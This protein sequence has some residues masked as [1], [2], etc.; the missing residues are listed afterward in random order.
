MNCK[1]A[2]KWRVRGDEM[3][4]N[5]T[6]VYLAVCI[7]MFSLLSM[8][9]ANHYLGY[10]LVWSITSLS[11]PVCLALT[12]SA[13][14]WRGL[15]LLALILLTGQMFG[16]A[17]YFMRTSGLRHPDI[18]SVYFFVAYLKSSGVIALVCYPVGFYSS[19]WALSLR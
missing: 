19:R 12:H 15:G 1:Y 18:E 14:F 3:Q 6:I 8:N 16:F 5:V 2:P 9:P 11:Y 13:G 4:S 7:C 17:L 10:V